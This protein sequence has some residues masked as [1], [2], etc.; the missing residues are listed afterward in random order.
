MPNLNISI[1]HHLSQ[2]EALQRIKDAIAHAKIQYSGNIN[3]L[4]ENWNANVGTFG[5]SAM[6]QA[7][8]GT[9]TVGAPEVV[10]DLEL[11]FAATFFKG[12]IEAGIREFVARLLG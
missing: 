6:G 10:V 5:G 7:L 2:D 1:L 8:S 11:P 12:Q 4:Q 9:I 3:G